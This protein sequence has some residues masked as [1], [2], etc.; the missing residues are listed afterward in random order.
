MKI[1]LNKIEADL[2]KDLLQDELE[3]QDHE[4]N[5]ISELCYKIIEQVEDH[6]E[7]E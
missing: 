7:D 6:K 2:L 1:E 4:K 3:W 5:A